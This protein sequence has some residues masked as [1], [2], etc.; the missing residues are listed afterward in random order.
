MSKG[1]RVPPPPPS[2]GLPDPRLQR[3]IA[4]AVHGAI[5]QLLRRRRAILTN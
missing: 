5:V 4:E 2:D 3:K 1:R